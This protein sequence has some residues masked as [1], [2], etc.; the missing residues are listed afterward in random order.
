[1]TLGGIARRH[2]IWSASVVFAT[3]GLLSEGLRFGWQQPGQWLPDVLT[4]WCL[5]ACGIAVARRSAAGALFCA[6]GVLWFAN[7]VVGHSVLVVWL[8]QQSGYWHRAPLLHIVITYPAVA[9]RD[10]PRRTALVSAYAVCAVPWVWAEPWAASAL[11]VALVGLRG[12][13]LWAA[14][15]PA[16]SAARRGLAGA[17][18]LAAAFSIGPVVLSAA[19]TTVGEGT[20]LL[21]YEA[22]VCAVAVGLAIPLAQPS[23]VPVEITDLVVLVTNAERDTSS[24][25][26]EL[27]TTLGDA[28]LE[29]GYWLEDAGAYIDANGRTLDVATA[30]SDRAVTPVTND[31]RPVAV[32]VHDPASLAD[33]QVRRAV[34][35]AIRLGSTNARLRLELA[36]QLSELESSARRIVRS[37]MDARERIG[38]QLRMGAEHRL[39]TVGDLLGGAADSSPLSPALVTPVQQRLRAAVDDLARL[40]RGLHPR[41]LAEDGLE[42]ALAALLG[43]VDVACRQ[44]IDLPP[45]VPDDL[46]AMAYFVCSEAVTNV[47]KHAAASCVQ[48]TVSRS[49]AGELLVEVTDDGCGGAALSAGSGLSGLADRVSSFGGRL[50]LESPPGGGTHLTARVPLVGG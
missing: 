48:V 11:G 2:V 10:A 31:G 28:S 42:A 38:R 13:N 50:E 8:E 1:V 45:G 36:A 43:D 33:P 34:E 25:R 29:L 35:L 4:G 23:P 40:A 9:A 30:S 21:V 12:A 44:I 19:G 24:L 49:A 32:L 37:G 16:R 7:N 17:L 20:T 6:S 15:G 41:A 14:R 3:V 18:G 5:L 22:L 47:V 46:L 26:R 27:A 39:T